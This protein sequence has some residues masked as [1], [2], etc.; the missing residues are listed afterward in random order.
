MPNT[1]TSDLE[2]LLARETD[3]IAKSKGCDRTVFA[4]C[5]TEHEGRGACRCKEEARA[6]ITQSKEQADGE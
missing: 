1:S 6:L 5:W 4:V 3:R 2:A